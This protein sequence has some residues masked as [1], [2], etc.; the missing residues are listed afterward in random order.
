MMQNGRINSPKLKTSLALKR[1][2]KS[3]NMSTCFEIEESIKTKYEHRSI[4]LIIMTAINLNIGL[5]S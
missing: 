4:M 2:P 3:K 1:K 5:L